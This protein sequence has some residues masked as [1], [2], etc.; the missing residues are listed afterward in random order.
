[1]IEP[2]TVQVV[3]VVR[4]VLDVCPPELSGDLLDSGVVLTGGGALVRG[5]AE[6]LRHELGVPVRLADEPRHAVIRGAG[7][8]VDDM[9][10]LHRVLV[11][12]PRG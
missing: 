11:G 3:E 2:V 10:A 6:R 7:I 12:E 8:C 4:A 1:M 5:W 9:R